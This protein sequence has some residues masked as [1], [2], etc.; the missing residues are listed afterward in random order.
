MAKAKMPREA[1]AF[2]A[3]YKP[4]CAYLL[5]EAYAKLMADKVDPIEKE[6]L[7]SGRYLY[8]PR[9]RVDPGPCYDPKHAYLMFD[10]D[11]MMFFHASDEAKREAGLVP[12]DWEWS[13][14]P[15]LVA[16]YT[17]MKAKR[18]VYDAGA[19]VFGMPDEI[20]KMDLYEKAVDLMV[21]FVVNHPDFEEPESF[22]E[23]KKGGA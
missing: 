15:K 8:D 3:L 16:E 17:A 21:K 13:R 19:P 10:L 22:K 5:A 12:D 14:C 1:V 11:S 2:A 23:L 4:V 20:Y 7:S 6:I 18:N 9:N